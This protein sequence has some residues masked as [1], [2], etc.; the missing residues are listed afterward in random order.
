MLI[1]QSLIANTSFSPVAD[2]R[3]KMKQEDTIVLPGFVLINCKAGRTVSAV[4]YVAPPNKESATPIFTN[5]V[6]K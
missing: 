6:P 1:A 3:T 5:I 4:E 2:G